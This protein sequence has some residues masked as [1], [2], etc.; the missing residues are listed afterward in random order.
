MVGGRGGNDDLDRRISQGLRRRTQED[1]RRCQEEKEEGK[2]P[3][4]TNPPPPTTTDRHSFIS[5]NGKLTCCSEASALRFQ[6]HSI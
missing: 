5:I 6:E 2:A 4:F 1:R 3:A